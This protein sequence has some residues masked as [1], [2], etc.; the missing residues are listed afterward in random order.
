MLGPKLTSLLK[1]YEN[2]IA[3]RESDIT[4]AELVNSG[5]AN[6]LA[7]SRGHEGSAILNPFL[8]PHD[9]LCCHYRD[10][11]LMLAR[12]MSNEQFFFTALYAKQSLILLAGKWF[13]T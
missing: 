10:K 7:S 8:N 4:E 13:L 3:S 6:F 12:G 9:W 1:T 11:A 2:M 5:E